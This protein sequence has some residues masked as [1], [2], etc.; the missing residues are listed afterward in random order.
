MGSKGGSGSAESQGNSIA[1]SGEIACWAMN[2]FQHK[3]G[4]MKIQSNALQSFRSPPTMPL[5][6]IRKLQNGRGSP[7][8]HIK[9]YHVIVIYVLN[10]DAIIE[11][12]CCSW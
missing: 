12:Y 10:K 5:A 8:H 3:S 2:V 4:S 11:C 7:Y 9:N 1:I 6:R